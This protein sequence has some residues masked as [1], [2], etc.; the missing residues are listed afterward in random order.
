MSTKRAAAGGGRRT[1]PGGRRRAAHVGLLSVLVATVAAC[2]HRVDHDTL[3]A[4]RS[5]AAERATE[6]ASEAAPR[7]GVAGDAGDALGPPDDG[8]QEVTTGPTVAAGPTAAT[9][10][11]GT[12]RATTA[13]AAGTGTATCTGREEPIVIGT[14]GQLSGPIGSIAGLGPK[15]VQVWAQ[16]WNAK[17]GINCHK[18]RYLTYDDGGDPSRQQALVQQLIE[19]DKAIAI[20]HQPAVLTGRASVA[21]L[22]Q[23][24]IPVIGSEG[25][26]Y[27]QLE[28]ANYFP[29]AATGDALF[30]SQA[31][32][33]GEVGR[34]LGKK[35]FGIVSCLEVQQC[36]RGG[37]VISA[38]VGAFGLRAAYKASGS[39][40]QPDFTANCQAA[41]DAGVELLAMMLDN[42]SMRR[43]ARS[44][45]AISYRP[46]YLAVS[47][48][49]N[50]ELAADP[51]MDGII[52]P[53]PVRPVTDTA[54]AAVKEYV[55]A[56]ARYSTLAPATGTEAGWA[57]AKIFE[58][59]A[60]LIPADQKPTAKAI[61]DGLYTIKGD[62]L[63]GLT[64][65]LTFTAGRPAAN[66]ACYWLTRVIDGEFRGYG[67][68]EPVCI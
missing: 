27:W 55:D 51:L 9:D 12:T 16:A 13:P 58:I 47:L 37:D 30:K 45:A 25:A 52:V 31:Q 35:V 2:G 44:C 60:K 21:F 5:R 1:V 39:L 65:R 3:V 18:I 40:V 11:G 46:Q 61:L 48:L 22:T 6:A 66:S 63:G 23:R 56:F 24:Q 28:H 7:P 14:V 19:R 33:Y 64:H 20:V 53:V 29:Q 8:A 62:D 41:R 43:F 50:A 36:T 49:A 15:A 38:S 17:G 68:K 57:S 59:A 4:A 54:N 32:G 10:G 26:A 34:M 42:N 67:S